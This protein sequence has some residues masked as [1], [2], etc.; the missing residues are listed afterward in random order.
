MFVHKYFKYRIYPNKSTAY[1][2][3]QWNYALKCLWNISNEQRKTGY[4]RP[5]GE[6]IYP[7]YVTQSREVTELR[8][9]FDWINDVPRQACSTILTNLDYAWTRCFKN[10]S[11]EPKWKRKSC[12]LGIACTSPRNFRIRNNK[13]TFPKISPIPIVMSRPLE[14]KPKSCTIKR[15][16][17]QWFVSI[18]CEIEIPDPVLKT[19][20][21][22]GIDCG[23]INLIADSDR[24][25]LKNPRFLDKGLQRLVRAQRSVSRKVKGSNN[26]KKAKNKVSRIHRKIRRQRD[27]LLHVESTRYAK[28]HGTVVLEKLNTSGMSQGNLSRRILDSGW[29]KFSQYLQYKLHWSGGTLTKVNPAYTSQTCAKCDH[30]DRASRCGDKFKCTKCGHEDH[31]DLNAA[32]IVL[33]RASR[34]VQPVEGSKQR[35]PRRSRKPKSVKVD[36]VD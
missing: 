27:H 5:N 7:S 11:K 12:N 36:L 4:G 13:L 1:R 33:R 17:D 18:L 26:Q 28:S 8:K 16:G 19:E 3:D 2:L 14:G 25:L 6:K 35:L 23:V 31:A 32:Q 9:S 24:R 21:K 30:I 34:P 15:D 29:G 10:V 22:I 20:P